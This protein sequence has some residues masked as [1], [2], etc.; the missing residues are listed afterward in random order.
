MPRFCVNTVDI[1]DWMNE[2]TWGCNCLQSDLQR[3]IGASGRWTV[4]YGGWRRCQVCD[5][6]VAPSSSLLSSWRPRRWS[7]QKSHRSSH[8]PRWSPRCY[9]C[10]APTSPPHHHHN[11]RTAASQS[12]SLRI[13]KRE[14]QRLKIEDWIFSPDPNAANPVAQRTPL[15]VDGRDVPALLCLLPVAPNLFTATAAADNV[16]QWEADGSSRCSSCHW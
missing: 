8:S 11:R 4:I 15:D 10:Q 16:K 1:F 6:R 5:L 9:R 2:V 3:W 13:W 12:K 14:E 7:S